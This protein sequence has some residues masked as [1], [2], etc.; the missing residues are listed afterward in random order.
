[1]CTYSAWAE[2]WCME[3]SNQSHKTAEETK[4]WG[5]L[6][7]GRQGGSRVLGPAYGLLSLFCDRIQ[8]HLFK[9]PAALVQTNIPRSLLKSD[10]IWGCLPLRLTRV[11]ILDAHTDHAQSLWCVQL[12]KGSLKALEN[13]TAFKERLWPRANLWITGWME[14]DALLPPGTVLGPKGVGL[15][16][17][18]TFNVQDFLAWFCLKLRK[19]K[20]NKKNPKQKKHVAPRKLVRK[21]S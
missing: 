12:N 19:L 4:G 14:R 8:L 5:M 13:S 20:R 11:N 7:W 21:R 15:Q 17:C 2:S 18:N 1:M 16:S 6:S 10:F 9:C 3:T